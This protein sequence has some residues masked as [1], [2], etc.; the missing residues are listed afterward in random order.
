MSGRDRAPQIM[1]EC[2][3]EVMRPLEYHR[4]LFARTF[5]AGKRYKLM[6]F[7][8]RSPETHNHYFKAVSRYWDNWPHDYERAL[9][10]REQLRKHAL[11]RTGHYVQIAM[12]FE[13]IEAASQFV[14]TYKRSVDYTEGS[15]IANKD[16]AMAVMLVAKTQQKDRMDAG[17]FQKSKQDVLEFCA[18]VTGVSPEQMLREVKK[19]AA[20]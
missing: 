1:F 4:D 16:G 19:G 10:D 3:G 13:S 8:E 6:E 2:T 11:I 17:E 12:A 18:A 15:L 9:A 7:S 14:A 20:A 5:E